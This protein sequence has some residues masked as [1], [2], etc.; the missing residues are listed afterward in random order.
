MNQSPG[1]GPDLQKPE[2]TQNSK[3]RQDTVYQ[4]QV[5]LLFQQFQLAFIAIVLIAP[6]FIV[7]LSHEQ[8][9]HIL[10]AWLTVF[11]LV[12][13]IRL[14]HCHS[15][16]KQEPEQLDYPK[17]EKQ[18]LVG[19]TISGLIWG[20][21]ALLFFPETNH[22]QQAFLFFIVAGLSGGALSTLSYRPL[23]FR[24]FI[25]TLIA[26]F[27][28]KL[29]SMGAENNLIMAALL[30]LFLAIISSVSMRIYH[31]VTESYELRFENNQLLE[32]YQQLKTN[33]YDIDNQIQRQVEKR[34][35]PEK[36]LQETEVFLHS[37]L[38]TANDVIIT[39]DQ[40]GIILSVNHAALRDFGYAEYELVGKSITTLMPEG[41]QK[42]HDLF[43]QQYLQNREQPIEG[44]T[45]EVEGKKKDGTIF[46]IE[47]TLSEATINSRIFYTAIM[48]DISARKAEGAR[49]QA[50]LTDLQY[51]RNK[52]EQD[53]T[54]L[55]NNYTE[56]LDQSLN[57]ELTNLA[58][59][60]YLMT[61][62]NHEWYRCQRSKKHLSIVKI[63]VDS[64][65]S[66]TERYGQQA[67]DGCLIRISQL[68]KKQLSRSS[69]FLAR[70]GDEQFMAMLPET[71]PE[72]A[73]VIAE[74]MRQAIENIEIPN[75]NSTISKYVTIS[76]GVATVIPGHE[77]NCH[78]LLHSVDQALFQAQ[79]IGCNN[80]QQAKFTPPAKNKDYT[81]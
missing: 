75:E 81:G 12:N 53:N 73:Y 61:T 33:D 51:A 29:I 52:L 47:I 11:W 72:G 28:I 39:S 21:I 55:Q 17:W 25:I 68:L 3:S 50:V 7:Y 18:F 64:F 42:K 63:S 20:S 2:Y 79:N 5:S 1:F 38:S 45:L 57:D 22:I 67:S 65:K 62:L 66:Y 44:R 8:N 54:D 26:P 70:Y 71:D 23:A 74:K 6:L 36:V 37:V 32:Q 69:D 16:F 46:P 76:C 41:L 10:I 30:T 58:N 80:I 49:L 13:L 19:T 9:L 24:L 40:K 14:Y 35:S 56:L 43:M 78:A 15:F 31:T 60:R 27:V 34:M 48:R 4:E 77:G 59:R